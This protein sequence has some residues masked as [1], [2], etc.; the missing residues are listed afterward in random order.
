MIIIN[1]DVKI[2]NANTPKKCYDLDYDADL[3]ENRYS[4]S[5]NDDLKASA[6]TNGSIIKAAISAKVQANS[7]EFPDIKYAFKKFN[8][9][10]IIFISA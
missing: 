1:L 5:I 7:N 10:C 2:M 3:I 6:S 4:E 8:P 9:K